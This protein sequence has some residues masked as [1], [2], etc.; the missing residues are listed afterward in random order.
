MMVLDKYPFLV[1][2][3]L[4][5]A[6]DH[7]DEE[8]TYLDIETFILTQDRRLMVIANNWLSKLS[9]DDFEDVCDGEESIANEI[10]SHSPHPQLIDNLLNDFFTEITNNAIMSPQNAY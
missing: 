2:A 9:D 10:L 1:K 3:F 4:I 8:Q 5:I 7:L 6:Y